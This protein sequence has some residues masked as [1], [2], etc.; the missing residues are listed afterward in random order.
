LGFRRDPSSD[1]H[2]NSSN[3]RRSHRINSHRGTGATDRRICMRQG[4]WVPL[5]PLE[6]QIPSAR[7]TLELRALDTGAT[8]KQ[9]ILECCSD[10]YWSCGRQI[11]ELQVTVTGTCKRPISVCKQ[12]ILE[13][14]A[15]T[16]LELQARAGTGAASNRYWW[17]W[18][19]QILEPASDRYWSLRL[20]DTGAYKQQIA[21]LQA[22]AT[23]A[24]K[25]Q[26]PVST[27]SAIDQQPLETRK[28]HHQVSRTNR[29]AN[30][31]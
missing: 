6:R 21:G 1:S 28:N 20:P 11:L 2:W 7:Q 31:R 24:Y 14:Q 27:S 9:S 19:R 4:L 23:A 10:Q 29:Q 5:D 26:I 8:R 30:Y 22:T 13:L 12:Q 3:S 17:S 16:L 15:T 25:R 18:K